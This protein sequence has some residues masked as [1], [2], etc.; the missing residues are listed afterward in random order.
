M[1]EQRDIN[2]HQV[3][4][5][6]NH[7]FSKATQGMGYK[8]VKGTELYDHQVNFCYLIDNIHRGPKYMVPKVI[9][10]A[11]TLIDEIV[12]SRNAE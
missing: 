12:E 5:Y 6:L 4:K 1:S 7:A 11:N 8:N 9:A 2:V 3:T 10:E